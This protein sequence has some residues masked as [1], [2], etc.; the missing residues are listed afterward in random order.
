MWSFLRTVT[1]TH[2]STE[3]IHFPDFCLCWA[4]INSQ[5]SSRMTSDIFLTTSFWEMANLAIQVKWCHREGKGKDHFHHRV[6]WFHFR[7][8]LN[9]R[10]RAVVAPTVYTDPSLP[11][12][13]PRK[14]HPRWQPN[15]RCCDPA[16]NKDILI[17]FTDY[18]HWSQNAAAG[19][20]GDTALVCMTGCT[21]MTGYTLIQVWGNSHLFT[22][23][24]V[25]LRVSAEEHK[26]TTEY[27]YF[28]EKNNPNFLRKYS[29][30]AQQSMHAKPKQKNESK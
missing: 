11:N 17:F 29:Q 20:A 9:D 3:N 24:W 5:N 16:N 2:R 18:N 28:S 1:V 14:I 13:L 8:P 10:H 15:S 21:G 12:V 27:W 19:V 25:D 22:Q 26:Q 30:L 6:P 7:A 4:D 23:H